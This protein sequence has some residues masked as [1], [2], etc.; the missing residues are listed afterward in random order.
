MTL[1]AHWQQKYKNIIRDVI[2]ILEVSLQRSN[3]QRI[4]GPPAGGSDV[5]D[6]P[7]GGLMRLLESPINKISV[8]NKLK[9]F[10]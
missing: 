10:S 4:T 9:L 7:P 6:P 1:C 5:E 2:F 8:Y 3:D